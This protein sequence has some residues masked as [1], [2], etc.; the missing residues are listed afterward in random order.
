[1]LKVR[2]KSIETELVAKTVERDLLIR[3]SESRDR[4]MSGGRER[5]RELRGADIAKPEK[6]AEAAKL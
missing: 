6:S 4:E 1:V 5:M 2:A 3:T